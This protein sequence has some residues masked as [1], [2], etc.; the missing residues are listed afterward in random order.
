MPGVEVITA[1]R[2]GPSAPLAAASGQFFAVG[3]AERGD[4]ANPILIRGAADMAKYLGS[5]Q[6]Y[7]ATLWDNLATFFNEGGTQAYVS[8]VTGPAA[9]VGTLTLQ[10]KAGSP[11]NTLRVDAQNPGAWSANLKVAVA[12]GS[13]P[14]TFRLTVTLS[15]VVVEDYNNLATPTAAVNAFAKS[16]YVRC[17]DL[18]SVTAAPNNIPAPLA[19]TALS[20]GNDDRA[21]VTPT[22]LIAGLDRFNYTLGDGAVS[23]PGYNTA[24]VWTGIDTHCRANRR[25][26]ILA[27][28]RNDTKTTLL[29]RTADLDSEYSAVFAPWVRISD[30]SGGYVAISPEGYVAAARARAHNTVGPWKAAAGVGSVATTL[31]DVDGPTFSVQDAKDLDDGR[32]NVIRV[33]ANSI[34][35][36]GW[37]SFSSDVVN[38]PMI[39]ARDTLNWFVTRCEAAL[40]NYVFATVDAKGQLL[41][42]IN[43]AIVGVAEPVR[44]AGGLY[45]LY[46][47]TGKRIDPGYKVV[48]DSSVNTPDTLATNVVNALLTVRLSPTGGLIRLTIVKAGL[49]SGL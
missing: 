5:R 48:T 42:A 40:E 33:V 41:S 21:A 15:G 26:G 34:R 47:A 44:V 25:V 17:T 14:N 8:R 11:L 9:S 2:Q 30:G 39:K 1:T 3:I 7:S 43:A 32:I 12:A 36:Y 31:L 35:L 49:T 19:A 29:S 28:A 20:A 24:A 10:D 38:Y 23:I 22:M 16:A 27:S 13:I 6:S 45:E 18:A 37:R 46:D 4:N